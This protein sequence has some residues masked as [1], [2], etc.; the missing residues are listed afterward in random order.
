MDGTGVFKYETNIEERNQAV[1]GSNPTFGQ[2]HCE[3]NIMLPWPWEHRRRPRREGVVKV[4]T[5]EV[6]YHP[7]A[8]LAAKT[9]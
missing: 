3:S 4:S 5:T 1:P 8:N 9:R 7:G 2:R 6:L